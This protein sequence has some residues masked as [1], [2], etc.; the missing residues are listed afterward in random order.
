ESL[1]GRNV[2]KLPWPYMKEYLFLP[3]Y[4]FPDI[5]QVERFYQTIVVDI[6]GNKLVRI[7]KNRRIFEIPLQPDQ[8]QS[9]HPVAIRA[10]F[11]EIYEIGIFRHV[12]KIGT[13]LD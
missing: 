7:I 10:L 2:H 13:T 11:I 9:R 1:V 12:H 4:Q 8:V 5:D 6:S 3:Q